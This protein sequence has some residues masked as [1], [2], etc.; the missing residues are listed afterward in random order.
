MPDHD[1]IY[2]LEP[3]RY[4]AL[5]AREDYKGNLWEAIK[6]IRSPTGLDVLELGAGTG[7]LTRLLAPH[8]RRLTAADISPA[9]LAENRRLLQR[10]ALLE[11]VA[12]VVADHRIA[13]DEALPVDLVIAG[14]SIAYEVCRPTLEEERLYFLLE[15]WNRM[16]RADGT[17][18]IIETQGT[19]V[20]HPA[21][22]ERLEPY[23]L[24]LLMAGFE[25]TWIRTDYRFESL[26]EAEELTRFFF[27]DALADRVLEEQLTIL[28]ECTGLWWRHGRRML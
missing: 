10:A 4:E 18:L 26:A 9:M 25:S 5:V 8:V 16:L 24:M 23:Y 19:G 21:P 7:R 22:P 13:G 27:G 15:R 12:L 2:R 20:E 6:S 1:A 14:W 3:A 28:P 17:I 11:K